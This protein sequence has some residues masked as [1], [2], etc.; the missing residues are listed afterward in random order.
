MRTLAVA[1]YEGH[2]VE[3][4]TRAATVDGLRV[5]ARALAWCCHGGPPLDLADQGTTDMRLVESII[6][7]LLASH[8]S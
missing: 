5:K 6:G 8:Q 2:G 4:I 7:D 3:P 1:A